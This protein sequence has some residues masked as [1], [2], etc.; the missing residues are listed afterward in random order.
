MLW[1]IRRGFWYSEMVCRPIVG[2]IIHTLLIGYSTGTVATFK[3]KESV[4]DNGSSPKIGQVRYGAFHVLAHMIAGVLRSDRR[5]VDEFL[6]QCNNNRC[7]LQAER[8]RIGPDPS[9]VIDMTGEGVMTERVKRASRELEA[10]TAAMSVVRRQIR[11][12]KTLAKVLLSSSGSINYP[13]GSMEDNQRLEKSGNIV[14]IPVVSQQIEQLPYALYVIEQA[15]KQRSEDLKELEEMVGQ[16]KM[17]YDG[18]IQFVSPAFI[19][20]TSRRM[21]PTT[22]TGTDRGKRVEETTPSPSS[23]QPAATVPAQPQNQSSGTNSGQ[24][25]PKEESPLLLE[26]LGHLRGEMAHLTREIVDSRT[27]AE[28]LA[29]AQQEFLAQILAQLRADAEVRDSQVKEQLDI[30]VTQSQ[31]IVERNNEAGNE[32]QHLIGQL[33]VQGDTI[34]WQADTMSWFTLVTFIFLPLAFFTQVRR[35][36]Q[37]P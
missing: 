15:A 10:V 27:A 8:T 5:I 32:A 18:L 30:M 31:N 21:E 36:S 22:A 29:R 34:A 16:T 9:S 19:L 3:S 26:S 14:E 37:V 23:T 11:I 25:E 24:Q 12:L 13:S 2:D 4:T 28:T 33:Q 35:D 1:F 7:Y 6:A 20:E 17:A